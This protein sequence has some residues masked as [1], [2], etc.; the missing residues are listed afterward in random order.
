MLRPT[1]NNKL[2]MQWK[3]PFP[4]VEKVGPTDY[5]IQVRKKTKVYHINML[6]KY[7]R[8]QN[9]V[10]TAALVLEE[11]DAGEKDDI[12]PTTKVALCENKPGETYLD[13]KISQLLDV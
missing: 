12:I 1:S 11:S 3:E 7:F 5:K 4:V 6:K 13:V 10:E 9:V 8:R 2:L